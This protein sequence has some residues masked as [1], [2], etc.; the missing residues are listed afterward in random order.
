MFKPNDFIRVTI[1]AARTGPQPGDE[2]AIVDSDH[3]TSLVKLETGKLAGKYRVIGNRRLE[4]RNGVRGMIG[5][6]S[7]TDEPECAWHQVC[8]RA[9]PQAAR[10]P[11]GHVRII[12]KGR[13]FT[14]EHASYAAAVRWLKDH[15]LTG[16]FEVARVIPLD[17]VTL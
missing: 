2:G 12:E 10:P 5:C 17:A 7:C 9:T 14:T 3:A 15:E 1:S 8:V 13:I 11:Q 16:A 6:S 4:L